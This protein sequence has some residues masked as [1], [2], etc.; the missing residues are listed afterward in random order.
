MDNPRIS[1]RTVLRSGTLAAAALA[2]GGSAVGCST[3]ETV[4]A[5]RGE[6]NVKARLPSYHPVELIK[7]DLP[8]NEVLMP[9]YYA[10]PRNPEPAFQNPPGAGLDQVTIMY[11]T[12]I[13][14][15]PRPD[16]NSFYAQVQEELGAELDLTP[17]PSPDY[18]PKFQTMIAGGDLP[19]IMMFPLPTPDQPRVMDRLFA[20]LGPYLAGD[21]IK[22]Y[23]FL[24][25]IPT[26]SWRPAISNGTVYAV[27]QPRSLAGQATYYRRDLIEQ[28]GAN[29]EPA[30]YD[31]VV[32]LFKAVT[33]PKQNRWAVANS[34]F[35]RMVV[36][37]MLG[38]PNGWQESGGEF[39]SAWG[40]ERTKESVARTAE[41]V[42]MGVFH[43]DAASASYTQF[44]DYFF[45]GRTAFLIDGYAGWD[46]FVRQL[47]GVAE[48]TRKLGLMVLPKYD[49]GGDAAHYAG[50]GF[51]A[52]T[53][54][55]KGLG[56]ERTRGLLGVLNFLAAP[57]GSR[58]HLHR[59][60]GVEGKD[61]TWEDGL[62]VLTQ[63]GNTNFLDL[64]YIA[65]APTI[66]GPGPKEGVDLQHAWHQRATKN[67]VK[68]PTIGLYSDTYSRKGG[69][70][71][72]VM[73]DVVTGI[74]FGR[75]K[76]DEYDEAYQRWRSE[77]G[78]KIAAEYAEAFA[79]A[80]E[81]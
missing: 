2:V 68:D 14:T 57:I 5:N 29:P 25:N 10:Y 13:A 32:E 17:V 34:G 66:I 39:T 15:P 55:R 46:L 52:I 64:Q 36:A 42:K 4:E 80:N 62:P 45:A 18:N 74:I 56:E 20:D 40:D 49:G 59:K 43:P 31:E 50:T 21:A 19:E 37:E 24:A 9:G 16:R 79:A 77:G 26:D 8:G 51:Q 81:G 60:F 67:L 35:T 78:D 58:E 41:L 38:A 27:P 33:D 28:V 71:G 1:R 73:G 70:L 54:I 48:G 7:P 63:Q 44:R 30:S 72:S 76:L 3:D 65:D 23:P 22:D 69:P 11:P 75:N 12:F 53:V 6:A 47:G 61:F